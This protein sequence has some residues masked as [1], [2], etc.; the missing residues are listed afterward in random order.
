MITV[1]SMFFPK[2]KGA[3]LWLEYPMKL[4]YHHT[5]FVVY[6]NV[7]MVQSLRLNHRRSKPPRETCLF[8]TGGRRQTSEQKPKGEAIQ[9]E[10]DGR[11]FR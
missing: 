4:L 8:K 3:Y 1:P 11:V 6:S 9:M 7:P 5:V 10:M 2:T